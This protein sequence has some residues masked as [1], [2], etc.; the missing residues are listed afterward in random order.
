MD[1]EQAHR[2]YRVPRANGVCLEVRLQGAA[3]MG[4]GPRAVPPAEC[5]AGRIGLAFSFA[6]GAG[7]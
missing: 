5:E 3:R 6:T 1:D 4:A 7:V 2:S